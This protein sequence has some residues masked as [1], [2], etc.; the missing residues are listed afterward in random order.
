MIKLIND[1]RRLDKIAHQNGLHLLGGTDLFRLYQ[2]ENA[3]NMQDKLARHKIW[4]R[5]FS[6]SEK[7]IRLGIPQDTCWEPLERALQS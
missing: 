2:S 4:S 3:K 1:A 6:Y 5:I 7:C